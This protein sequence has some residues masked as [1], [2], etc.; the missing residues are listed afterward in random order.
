[1]FKGSIGKK[2]KRRLATAG[3]AVAA[4]I[5][6]TVIL[7]G[8][9]ERIIFQ[10]GW[11]AG[12]TVEDDESKIIK[13]VE[14]TTEIDV[15]NKKVKAVVY[16][17]E[18]GGFHGDGHTYTQLKLDPIETQAL[19]EQ[20]IENNHWKRG[21]ATGYEANSVYLEDAFGQETGL[22]KVENGFYYFFDR[23][24]DNYGERSEGFS[25]NFDAAVLDIEN[26]TLYFGSFDS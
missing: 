3:F 15:H 18:Y 25:M 20:L 26:N 6:A 17:S 9:I 19:A 13:M 16:E 8:D 2:R 5:I 7:W 21:I 10:P 1:M 23:F 12:W 4:A 22:P 11:S 24:Y 14:A